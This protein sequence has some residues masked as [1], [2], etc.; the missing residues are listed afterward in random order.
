[1]PNSAG[2]AALNGNASA[3]FWVPT[4]LTV[5]ASDMAL[6]MG[7]LAGP[8]VVER[9]DVFAVRAAT[10]FSRA[11]TRFARPEGF[12]LSDGGRL[13]LAMDISVSACC[14]ASATM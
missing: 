2:F 11:F 12:R 8:L 9:E 5:A 1:M 6:A 4:N 13:L 14:L 3:T 10:P 7:L